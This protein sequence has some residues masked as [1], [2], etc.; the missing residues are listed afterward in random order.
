MI[1]IE[2]KLDLYL[3]FIYRNNKLEIF[4]RFLYNL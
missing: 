2:F 1:E 3:V 4:Q